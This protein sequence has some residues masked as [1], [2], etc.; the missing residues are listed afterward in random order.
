MLGISVLGCTVDPPPASIFF[1]ASSIEPT[2]IVITGA[3]VS[4]ERFMMPPLM[5][6]GSLAC[7][8]SSVGTVLT[9]V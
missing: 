7:M 4:D 6:P 9:V 5:A 1:R 3:G 8:V 2:W